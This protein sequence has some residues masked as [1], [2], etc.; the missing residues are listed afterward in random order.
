MYTP[1]PFVLGDAQAQAQIIRDYPF[2]TLVTQGPDGI[3]ATHLPFLLHRRDDGSSILAGHMARQ[4]PQ[5]AHTDH[6]TLVIFSGPHAYISPRWYET[7]GLVPTWNYIAVH[8]H[9][10]MSVLEDEAESGRHLDALIERFDSV[11]KPVIPAE[12]RAKLLQGIQAFEIAITQIEGKAKLSQNRSAAD[13]KGVVSG[14]SEEAGYEGA[15]L[16]AWMATLD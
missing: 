2:G 16:A 4:N 14:L 11:D 8:V 15:Q 12:T 9:G 3:H 6:P 13:R 1:K 5:L 10:T 7:P